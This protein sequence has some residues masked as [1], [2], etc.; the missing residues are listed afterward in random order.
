M[1]V[2]NYDIKINIVYI[3]YIY[4]VVGRQ[5]IIFNNDLWY[6]VNSSFVIFLKLNKYKN[7]F[8]FNVALIFDYIYEFDSLSRT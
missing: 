7:I 3:I 2:M 1:Q 4:Y 6:I 5:Q 8:T